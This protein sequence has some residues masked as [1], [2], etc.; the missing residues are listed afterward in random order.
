M[1]GILTRLKVSD[2]IIACT[3]AYSAF[4]PDFIYPASITWC[5]ILTFPLILSLLLTANNVFLSIVNQRSTQHCLWCGFSLGLSLTAI[6][7]VKGMFEIIS[8]VLLIAIIILALKHSRWQTIWMKGLL[9]LLSAFIVFSGITHTYKS[10]NKKYNGQYLIASNGAILYYGTVA[11]RLA[12]MDTEKFL[13]YI[14]SIPHQDACHYFFEDKICSY[15]LLETADEFGKARLSQIQQQN[16]NLRK[17][18]HLLFT[19]ANNHIL[20]NPL[21]YMTLTALETLKMF[22]WEYQARI[23]YAYYPSWINNIYA[24]ATIKN[25][26][27]YGIPLLSM[28]SFA[29]VLSLLWKRRDQWA[30]EMSYLLVMALIITLFVGCYALFNITG[31]YLA[32]VN[33][34][35]LMIIAFAIHQRFGIKQR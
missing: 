8:P 7:M 12:P 31:R 26:L 3:I 32:P 23:E 25:T 10:L 1:A 34:L 27:R 22:F 17:A 13:S 35:F 24:S 14:A 16:P 19:E 30:S 33:P 9:C 5:E 15:W 20:Q 4:S 28:L 29:Y 6:T 2:A 11:R 21:P 18:Q